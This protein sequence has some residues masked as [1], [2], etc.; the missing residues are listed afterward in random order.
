ML[1]T[2][3][4]KGELDPG[5]ATSLSPISKNAVKLDR[6]R[7]GPHISAE[8]FPESWHFCAKIVSLRQNCV[9]DV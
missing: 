9:Y 1:F 3:N 6:N 4:G 2:S 7:P 8:S 5:P